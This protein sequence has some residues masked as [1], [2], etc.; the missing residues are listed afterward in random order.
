MADVLEF[1]KQ[2]YFFSTFCTLVMFTRVMFLCLKITVR[3]MYA[4]VY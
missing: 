2:F 1:D 3:L 4:L